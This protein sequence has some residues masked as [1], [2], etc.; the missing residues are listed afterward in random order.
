MN[1]PSNVKLSDRVV[2]LINFGDNDFEEYFRIA[3]ERYIDKVNEQLK[4]S[5][6]FESPH[7]M[8]YLESIIQ[9]DYIIEYLVR[10]VAA[11]INIDDLD[12]VGKPNYKGNRM[13]ESRVREYFHLT[14]DSKHIHYGTGLVELLSPLYTPSKGE[15]VL[16][17][18][19][20][21][22]NHEQL[23]IYHLGNYFDYE[24]N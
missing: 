3:A 1:K 16:D 2:M 5:L 11:E 15:S 6:V 13:P 7:H 18:W 22:R 23:V 12:D 4:S 24:I 19:R 17:R 21:C 20:N 9:P 10:V 14:P 8:E